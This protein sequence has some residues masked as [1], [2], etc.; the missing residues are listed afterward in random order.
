MRVIRSWWGWPLAVLVMVLA[1][2][3]SALAAGPVTAPTGAVIKLDGQ[4]DDWA[5]IPGVAVP[6]TAIPAAYRSELTAGK[7]RTATLKVATDSKNI[8]V[9]VAIPDGYD[10]DPTPN[11]HRSPAIAV[12][13]QIDAAAG[14]AMG[15]LR[16]D[17]ATS[18]GMVDIWHWEMDCGPGKLSGGVFPTGNDP[19]CNLDDE[20]ATLTDDRHDDKAESSLTGSWDHT[21]RA[22]GI[23][24]DGTFVFEIARPL[25]NADPQD[26]QFALGG[27][28][29]VA[30]AYWDGNEGRARDGGWTDAGHA[31]SALDGD[32]WIVVTLASAQT[33][34]PVQPPPTVA[35]TGSGGLLA[36]L[37]RG[38][39]LLIA[40]GAVVMALAVVGGGRLATRRNRS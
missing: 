26:A 25:K 5:A 31:V 28:A 16:P 27:T 19:T 14:P 38:P 1:T 32:G 17:Y 35:K 18:G 34:A 13:W 39:S 12:E 37:G 9:L 3:G 36:E 20:Y 23:G 11:L 7:D 29:K 24:A 10:Y 2:T 40:L 6:L 33:T 30:V 21:A 8:Y 15:S 22:Q 4:M